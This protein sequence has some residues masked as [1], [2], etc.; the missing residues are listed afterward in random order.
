MT[1]QALES[2]K[3]IFGGMPTEGERKILLEMQASAEKT[4]AQ[5]KDIMIRA[6]AAAKSRGEYASR[7]ALAIRTGTYLTEGTNE[8]KDA[9]PK[10]KTVTLSDISATA[11][12][13]GKTAAEVTAAFRAKGYQV[14]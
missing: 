10:G 12:A 7:K 8:P 13:S 11:R 2:L 9:A 14:R 5:R 3:L 4:P 1:G 6:A